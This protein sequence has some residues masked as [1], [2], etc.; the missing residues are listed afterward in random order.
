MS[1]DTCHVS[2]DT[3]IITCVCCSPY[4]YNVDTVMNMTTGEPPPPSP[5]Q[6]ADRKTEQQS[7]EIVSIDKYFEDVD[8]EAGLPTLANDID[9]PGH[10]FD[11][12]EKPKYYSDYHN[13]IDTEH[14][15]TEDP[16]HDFEPSTPVYDPQPERQSYKK[17]NYL[18]GGPPPV[19]RRS[20]YKVP[21]LHQ[22]EFYYSKPIPVNKIVNPMRVRHYDTRRQVLAKPVTLN[23]QEYP[24][25]TNIRNYEKFPPKK[26]QFSG[27]R[28]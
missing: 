12:L 13:E 24:M 4:N 9:N 7:T 27:K 26:Y 16:W 20:K 1:T 15:H 19:F 8:Q 22:H 23:Q 14:F 28:R 25:V 17:T 21:S 10:S 11:Q 3:G 6:T 5:A 18:G 2:S